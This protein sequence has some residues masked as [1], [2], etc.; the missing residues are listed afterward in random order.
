MFILSGLEKLNV[1]IETKIANGYGSAK[2]E[3][4]LE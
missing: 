1:D 3:R 2:D 4:S